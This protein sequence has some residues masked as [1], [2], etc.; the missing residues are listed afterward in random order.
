MSFIFNFI[1]FFLNGLLVL[2][3]ELGQTLARVWLPENKINS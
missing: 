1:S 2:T 3:V